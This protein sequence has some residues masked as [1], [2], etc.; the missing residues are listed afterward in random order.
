MLSVSSYHVMLPLVTFWDSSPATILYLQHIHH[1]LSFILPNYTRAT[2]QSSKDSLTANSI[3]HFHFLSHSISLL[4]WTL[5]SSSLKPFYCYSRLYKPLSSPFSS[6]HSSLVFFTNSLFSAVFRWMLVDHVQRHYAVF[7]N[8][9]LSFLH[10][11]HLITKDYP[12]N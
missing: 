1:Q 7:L 10:C 9:S 6:G 2:L 11:K 8:F 12:F 4:H 3:W 5:P